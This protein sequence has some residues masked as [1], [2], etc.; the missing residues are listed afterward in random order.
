MHASQQ[1][2][3]GPYSKPA[4]LEMTIGIFDEEIGYRDLGRLRHTHTGYSTRG[5]M[6]FS[7]IYNNDDDNNIGAGAWEFDGFLGASGKEARHCIDIPPQYVC[8]VLARTR[9][10]LPSPR[11][12]HCD[13]WSH[14]DMGR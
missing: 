1:P 10:I 14:G 7:S 9:H 11:R 12:T 5:R 2:E 6:G 13:R 3:R 8:L 4:A